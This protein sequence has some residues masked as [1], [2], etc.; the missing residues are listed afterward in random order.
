[1]EKLNARCLL[2]ETVVEVV[3][4]GRLAEHVCRPTAKPL[5][6]RTPNR[7][8][9][10]AAS[11]IAAARK[12]PLSHFFAALEADLKGRDDRKAL[13]VWIDRL[14]GAVDGLEYRWQKP[15]T[16]EDKMAN[17]IKIETKE[18][19]TG[20]IHSETVLAIRRQGRRYEQYLRFGVGRDGADGPHYAF[21]KCVIMNGTKPDLSKDIEVDAGTILEIDGVFYAVSVHRGEDYYLE[22]DKVVE[23]R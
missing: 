21:G 16:R 13:E 19:S 18:I 14:L 22:L 11:M 15:Q 23:P 4:Y 20:S 8:Q 12:F 17:V 5:P 10:V 2:C 6:K 9:K 7:D 3:N 1:M